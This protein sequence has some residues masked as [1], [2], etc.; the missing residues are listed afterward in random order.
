M[1]D[2][3][4]RYLLF[5]R[6]AEIRYKPLNINYC[7]CFVSINIVIVLLI[8]MLTVKYDCNNVKLFTFVIVHQSNISKCISWLISHLSVFDN[9]MLLLLFSEVPWPHVCLDWLLFTEIVNQLNALSSLD[10]D[11]DDCIK[12]AHMPSARSASSSEGLKLFSSCFCCLFPVTCYTLTVRWAVS[13][14]LV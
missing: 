7:Y 14:V 8:K 10:E 2:S 6:V 4:R 9:S 3:L 1:A 11:P 12:Q 5:R 13:F